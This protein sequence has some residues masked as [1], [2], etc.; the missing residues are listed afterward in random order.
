MISSIF[1]KRIVTHKKV[2]YSLASIVL[3]GFLAFFSFSAVLIFSQFQNVFDKM[4]MLSVQ[5][6][7]AADAIIRQ[8]GTELT[9][10]FGIATV[11][12]L[13]VVWVFLLVYTHKMT[14]PIY[15]I[16]RALN[17]AADS[18]SWPRKISFRKKDAFHELSS[19]VNRFMKEMEPEPEDSQRE[20]A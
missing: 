1:K 11:A 18:R 19:A 14:G 3:G 4:K 13:V 10:R 8:L 2:Q 17:D 6:Q 12:Y 20:R 16:T 5:D 15:R 9:Y 7:L